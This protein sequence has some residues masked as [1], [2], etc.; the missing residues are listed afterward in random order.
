[1]SYVDHTTLTRGDTQTAMMFMKPHQILAM[2]EI[3]ELDG[4]HP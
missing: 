1:M 2:V 3:N 4:L